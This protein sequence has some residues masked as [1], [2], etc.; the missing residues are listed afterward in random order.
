MSQPPIDCELY[1]FYLTLTLKVLLFPLVVSAFMTNNPEPM[2][3]VHD[4]ALMP[5]SEVTSIPS[6]VYTRTEASVWL[7]VLTVIVPLAVEKHLMLASTLVSTK[8]Y[9]EVVM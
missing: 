5:D 7:G 8:V 2:L 9:V 4:A 6:A 1:I 3:F